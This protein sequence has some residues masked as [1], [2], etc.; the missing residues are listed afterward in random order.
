MEA[1]RGSALWGL[2][3]KGGLAKTLYAGSVAARNVLLGANL[4]SLPLVLRPRKMVEYVSESLFLYKAM[5][6]RRGLPE[7]NVYKL[8][9]AEEHQSIVLGHLRDPLDR[10]FFFHIPSYASDIVSLCLICQILKPKV[11]FEIGTAH[12]F[13]ALHFALNTGADATVYTLDLPQGQE[14]HPKLRTT[15]RDLEQS[16]G[17]LGEQNGYWFD[18]IDAGSKVTCLFGDSATFDFSRFHRRVDFFFIDGAHSYEY[19]RSDTL[20]AFACCHPGSIIAWHDFGRVGVNGVSRWLLELS[21]DL[22]IYSIPGGSLAVML[23]G[24]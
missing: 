6:G 16:A 7:K 19:V 10:T 24:P 21:K 1:D 11:V 3:R 23:V 8:L 9:P 13:S 18:G 12:G 14:I 4:A 17:S 5:S 20:N 22:E 2:L 15:L